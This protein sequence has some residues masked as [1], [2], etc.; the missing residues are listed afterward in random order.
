MT[1]QPP[2]AVNIPYL[3]SYREY[4]PPS[5]TVLLDYVKDMVSYNL[6]EPTSSVALEYNIG[7]DGDY[8][9]TLIVKNITNNAR[10][11]IRIQYDTQI[12]TITN[13]DTNQIGNP[14]EFII[15][16]EQTKNI[17]IKINKD[18]LNQKTEREV[19]PTEIK[20]FVTNLYN[21]TVITKNVSVAT[22]PREPVSA[23][24][25]II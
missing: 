24:I 17:T 21:S 10:L 11:K 18:N 5:G 15:P 25:S 1:I 8:P 14:V 7:A 19:I 23:S 13:P 2:A 4:Q 22:I 20:M 16:A 6:V 3:V 12:F 9:Q